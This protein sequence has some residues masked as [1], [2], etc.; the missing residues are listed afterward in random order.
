[1]L[2]GVFWSQ[3]LAPE[4][5]AAATM[6]KGE[7]VFAKI[8]ATNEIELGKMFKIKEYPAMY[9]LVNGGVQ[10]VTYDLTDERTR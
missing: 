5:A 8:D 6:L 4:Y 10:K 7:A 9:V 1:M 2:H 3:R